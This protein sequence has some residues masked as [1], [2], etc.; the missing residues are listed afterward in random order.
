MHIKWLIIIINCI[1][2]KMYS[3]AK[4]D[5]LYLNRYV[6][7]IPANVSRY[8]WELLFM[9]K[10][11]FIQMGKT[12]SNSRRDIRML[13]LSIIQTFKMRN[14]NT[15]D[16]LL[17]YS[18]FRIYSLINIIVLFLLSFFKFLYIISHHCLS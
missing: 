11:A 18:Y 4:M 13:F 5:P 14:N 9:P 17:N 12:A 2:D 6:S 10:T 16:S 3:C 15:V 1:H 8:K 7:M